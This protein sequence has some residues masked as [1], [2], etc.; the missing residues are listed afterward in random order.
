[1]LH[2]N[3]LFANHHV[4]S[5]TRI[6]RLAT[7]ANAYCPVLLP[8]ANRTVH[9]RSASKCDPTLPNVLIDGNVLHAVGTHVKPT[10]THASVDAALVHVHTRSLA[11]MVL[12]AATTR[13]PQKTLQ[14]STKL[15]DLLLSPQPPILD[16]FIAIV[17]LKASLPLHHS[18]RGPF[19]DS[20][21]LRSLSKS[22]PAMVSSYLSSQYPSLSLSATQ[23]FCNI[24]REAVSMTILVHKLC[25]QALGATQS[26]TQ[27]SYTPHRKKGDNYTQ[28]PSANFMNRTNDRAGTVNSVARRFDCRTDDA[29]T[30]AQHFLDT[31]APH[32]SQLYL[33]QATFTRSS[34]Q[35]P[36]LEYSF[37]GV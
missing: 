17:G 9:L 32:L 11:N 4:K 10:A 15:L 3:R 6:K 2:S 30:I 21:L 25:Q 28:Q 34:K 12:K 23:S 31:T 14:N 22:P 20:R 37:D 19:N 13:L 36:T 16:R 7:F 27:S 33:Q 24:S 26:A 29:A 5:M 35:V 18:K 8:R 1:M